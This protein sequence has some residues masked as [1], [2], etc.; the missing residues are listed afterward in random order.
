MRRVFEVAKILHD[1][2][3][4]HYTA[5]HTTRI[6]CAGSLYARIV[7]TIGSGT[8]AIAAKELG[9]EYIGIERDDTYVEV[10]KK[11]LD[12]TVPLDE[13]LVSGKL[14]AKV[15]RVALGLLVDVDQLLIKDDT[16]LF[17]EQ[18]E[19]DECLPNRFHFIL[20]CFE[21]RNTFLSIF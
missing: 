19:R 18:K 12:E 6:A 5:R 13:T 11:H 10:A 9:R 7:D 4:R 2:H 21:P 20:I 3:Y 16:V 14:E 8:T 1:S 15:P 17:I